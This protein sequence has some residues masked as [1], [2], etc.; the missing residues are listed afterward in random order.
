MVN[1]GI[2]LFKKIHKLKFLCDSQLYINHL[3][4]EFP[5][6]V[7]DSFL[8]YSNGNTY[9]VKQ[10]IDTENIYVFKIIDIV[11]KECGDYKNF[12]IIGEFNNNFQINFN[13]NHDKVI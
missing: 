11:F 6:K 2:Y 12:I 4:K 10:N 7:G 9:S 1:Q 13:N 8:L 5:V 3:T